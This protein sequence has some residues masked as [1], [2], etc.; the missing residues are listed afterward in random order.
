MTLANVG[1]FGT[2]VA[3]LMAALLLVSV[4]VASV[5]AQTPQAPTNVAVLPGFRLQPW[6]P[7]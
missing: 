6:P 1:S 3:P 5:L 7:A 2:S 4:P